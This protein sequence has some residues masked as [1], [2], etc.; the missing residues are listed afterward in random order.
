MARNQQSAAAAQQASEAPERPFKVRAIRLGYYG[1]TRRRP[2]D[3]FMVHGDQDMS[4]RWME[5]VAPTT[6]LT[7]TSAPEALRREHATRLDQAAP[8]KP[9]RGDEGEQPTGAKDPI[10]S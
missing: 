5:R 10:G 7:S 2:G 8:P 6:P 3:V 9:R 4:G 1:H